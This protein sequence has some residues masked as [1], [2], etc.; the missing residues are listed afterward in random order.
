MFPA[1]SCVSAAPRCVRVTEGTFN[2]N[3]WPNSAG[4]C[5]CIG[6]DQFKTAGKSFLKKV[7][8]WLKW[9]HFNIKFYS[10][11]PHQAEGWGFSWCYWSI[12]LWLAE[13]HYLWCGFF[14]FSECTTR[15]DGHLLVSQ[16]F[17]TVS[18]LFWYRWETLTNP[19]AAPASMW[20]EVRLYR[21]CPLHG[22]KNWLTIRTII[23]YDGGR[24]EKIRTE[25]VVSRCFLENKEHMMSHILERLPLL[26]S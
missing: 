6:S 16:T 22:G 25:D 4:G 2:R 23:G 9:Y 10:V 11:L 18:S 21:L 14:E 26:N 17:L 12:S 20:T 24:M 1:T 15:V 5:R 3:L 7:F 13:A 8:V 19:H